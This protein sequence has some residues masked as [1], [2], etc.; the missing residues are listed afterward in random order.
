MK[1][2]I[3]ILTIFEYSDEEMDFAAQDPN[4]SY[5]QYPVSPIFEHCVEGDQDS[6]KLWMN[7]ESYECKK[8]ELGFKLMSAIDCENSKIKLSEYNEY[9]LAQDIISKLENHELNTLY[10]ALRNHPNFRGKKEIVFQPSSKYQHRG[11]D[12]FN[13]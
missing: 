8:D 11:R 4:G 13:Y 3:K 1:R 7:P 12:P 5:F 6:E 10:E 2:K 9:A